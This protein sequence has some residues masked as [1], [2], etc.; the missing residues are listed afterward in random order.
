[1]IEQMD[2]PIYEIRKAVVR[3]MQHCQ[4]NPDKRLTDAVVDCLPDFFRQSLLAATS[5]VE[6]Q[7]FQGIGAEIERAAAELPVG[8]TIDISVEYGAAVVKLSDT[9]EDFANIEQSGDLA[10]DIGFAIEIATDMAVVDPSK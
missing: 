5:D 4:M 2:D 7:R 1:M 3:A 8:F 6:A 10:C 9:N